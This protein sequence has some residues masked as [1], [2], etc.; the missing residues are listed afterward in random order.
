MCLSQQVAHLS[1]LLLHVT[2]HCNV[3][4]I[5][6]SVTLLKRW[7]VCFLRFD[8]WAGMALARA[9]RIQEKLNSNELKSDVP[10]WKHSQAV[11]NCFKRALEIDSSNLSLWIEY[12]TISYAL[13]S[14]ASRQLKQWRN[15]LPPEVVKQ[16]RGVFLLLISIRY[17]NICRTPMCEPNAS[18][19]FCFH[20][21]IHRGVNWCVSSSGVTHAGSTVRL[22]CFQMEERRDSMLE[23]AFQCFQGAARCEC[24]SDEEEWLIH[25]MLGKIAEKRKQ[26]PL[27]YLQLYKKVNASGYKLI[28]GWPIMTRCNICMFLPIQSNVTWVHFFIDIDTL[29]LCGWRNALWLHQNRSFTEIPQVLEWFFLTPKVLNN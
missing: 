4:Y 29:K 11:L 2:K 28:H 7:T 12:G 1:A 21:W 25:Y 22:C 20:M 24:D 5:T 23:T 8:S 9:S 26:T 6:S 13:H 18:C 14:F 17:Q 3:F 15:E 16:V 19:H 10:I 27:D